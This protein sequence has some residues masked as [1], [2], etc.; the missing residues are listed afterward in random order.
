MS[1]YYSARSRDLRTWIQSL[2]I[3][4][5]KDHKSERGILQSSDIKSV[6]CK[7]LVKFYRFNRSLENGPAN[8]LRNGLYE[9]HFI[10]ELDIVFL[11]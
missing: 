10:R 8:N 3:R 5:Q 4:L 2:K 9:R 6:V 1:L 7:L 11:Q